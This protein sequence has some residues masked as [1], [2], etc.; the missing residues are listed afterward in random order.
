VWKFE[1]G[2]GNPVTGKI[3]KFRW[4]L[5]HANGTSKHVCMCEGTCGLFFFI[6]DSIGGKSPLQF[7]VQ[8]EDPISDYG[9]ISPYF[10]VSHQGDPETCEIW[11]IDETNNSSLKTRYSK[12]GFQISA[13]AFLPPMSNGS[14][15][16][17]A[18]SISGTII[19]LEFSGENSP[20][21]KFTLS[22]Q[23]F[24][25][26]TMICP[27]P[28]YCLTDSKHAGQWRDQNETNYYCATDVHGCESG[29]YKLCMHR[30]I[31]E[32]DIR[33]IHASHW[34]CCGEEDKEN[35]KCE[36]EQDQRYISFATLYSSGIIIFC[37]FTVCI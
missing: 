30:T 33:I 20:V 10:A 36:K 9:S 11:S 25:R 24:G 1:Q 3:L 27:C 4:G 21:C 22:Q 17:A 12:T 28:E 29:K 34:S 8:V 5:H 35:L 15:W 37:C 13:I 6:F 26:V 19:I 16:F 23:Q 7:A 2:K 31:G 18:G 32:S 14:T